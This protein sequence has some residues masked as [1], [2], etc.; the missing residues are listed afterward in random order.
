MISTEFIDSIARLPGIDLDA[1]V[2]AMAESPS[3]SIKLNKR[4]PIDPPLLGYGEL[5]KVKW[6][7]SGYYLPQRSIFTLN[8]L[9]HAGVFYV[10][11]ASSMIYETIVSRLIAEH[12]LPS[13]ALTL[14]MCAAPGGKST[15]MLNA[16]GDGSTLVANEYTSRRVGPLKENLLKWGYP[17]IMITNS[18]TA[19]YA[20]VAEVFDLVAVDAPCSGE[21]MMRKDEDAVAQWGPGLVRQCAELQRYILDNAVKTLRPGGYLIYS[22]CTF[23]RSEDE[24]N[25]RYLIEDLGMEPIDMDL[26]EEWGIGAAIDSPYPALRF[27]PHLTRGEGLFTAVVRK[28]GS[29]SR[30]QRAKALREIARHTHVILDGIPTTTAKGKVTLPAPESPLSVRFAA[31]EYPE[32]ELDRD[33]ALSYLRHEAITLP[34]GSPRGYTVVTY[35][36][37]RLG[38]VK[39]IGNRANNLHPSPWRIRMQSNDNTLSNN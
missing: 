15:S 11:D 20:K 6:C 34:A 23:N 21:G 27:M 35:L 18:D 2:R 1:F 7:D 17:D 13:D 14:D 10:Q 8:P 38:F 30:P 3:V 33:T 26:P 5:E 12:S 39:N 36:G 31:E 28:P 25:L 9:L 29:G 24:E 32:V 22:T 16:L 19:C 37:H 4:K